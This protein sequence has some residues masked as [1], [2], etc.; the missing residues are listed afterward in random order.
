[1]L[2][3][4][5]HRTYE[6]LMRRFLFRPLGIRSATFN[7]PAS[8]PANPVQPMGHLPDGSPVPGDRS[9]LDFMSG[10]LSPAGSILRMNVSDWT[11]FVRVHLGGTNQQL[12][13][14]ETLARLHQAIPLDQTDPAVGYAAGWLV[15]EAGTAG[16][17]GSLGRVLSHNG[18]DGYW[19]TDVTAFPDVDFSIQIMANTAVDREGND[20]ATSA[21]QEV[22]QRLL[23]RFAPRT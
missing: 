10:L 17:D 23:H 15:F 7:P 6:S 9:P 20:L 14:P 13:Q 1:M 5:T 21:F 19:L 18:S 12:I 11:R 8:D 4:A 3:R 22:R 16:L 2:E